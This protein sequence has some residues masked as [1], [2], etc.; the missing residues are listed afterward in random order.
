MLAQT[1]VDTAVGAIGNRDG[2]K[3]QAEHLRAVP[4]FEDVSDDYIRRTTQL[5]VDGKLLVR[6]IASTAQGVNAL[7]E[8]AA[9]LNATSYDGYSQADIERITENG[10]RHV[11]GAPEGAIASAL[12]SY[13]DNGIYGKLRS[14]GASGASGGP[15]DITVSGSY[16]NG[17]AHGPLI[18]PALIGSGRIAETVGRAI[19]E[20][21]VLKYTLIGLQ[22]AAGPA[23][24]AAQQS[25]SASSAGQAL[26]AGVQA[27]ADHIGGGFTAKDY[28][29]A[30]ARH[31]GVGAIVLASLGIGGISKALS[32]LSR[33]RTGKV[34]AE[35]SAT[36]RAARLGA[37]GEQAVGLFGP[38]VGIRV[39]GAN[40]LRFPDN[41][42]T[43]TL[44]EVKN[45]ASQGLTKQM[46]DYITISQGTGR[47][48][49][50]Y[51]R[52]PLA[53]SGQT[54]LTGPL[55]DAVKAGSVNLKFIPG[56][57]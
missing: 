35:E 36:A 26:D 50:L 11:V 38:K 5:I 28:A 7:N 52:G 4:G 6:E 32:S 51:V 33:L 43:T 8:T 20:R 16:E 31:A 29:T 12:Q 53:P 44:T 24:F 21:P 49:E 56:T 45:V 46:R 14:S 19:A 41:L 10:L 47:T 17:F 39:P 40:N 9:L 34:D 3:Q 15:G 18:D 13:R 30:D 55:L 37:E 42:T 25:F 22:I 1:I 54:V 48:F 23:V 57:F 27:A 2:F